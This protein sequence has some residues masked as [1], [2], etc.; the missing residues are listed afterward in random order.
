MND[1]SEGAE[2]A[3][4][5]PLVPISLTMPR[6]LLAR[7]DRAARRLSITRAAYIKQALSKAVNASE[8]EEG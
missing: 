7:I 6:E 3:A 5:E 1:S 2:L 8:I 4:R